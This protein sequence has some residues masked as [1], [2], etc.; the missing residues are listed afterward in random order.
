MAKLNVAVLMGGRS[1]EREVSLASGKNV[2][3][4]LD[5]AKYY[6]IPVEI[7]EDG[8]WVAWDMSYKRQYP[9]RLEPANFTAADKKVDVVFIALHGK[10][11]EDGTVQGF[12]EMMGVPYT[13]SGVLASALAM[14]KLLSKKIFIQE[15]IPTNEF[16]EVDFLS[17]SNK[18]PQILSRIIHKLGRPVVVKPS[19]EG[20]S[21][22][23]S[24]AYTDEQIAK[25]LDKAF[26]YGENVLA[27]RHL[28]AREIQCGIV[29]NKKPFALPLIEIISKK[30]FFDYEAKYT[31]ELAEEIVP[32]PI[33][34]EERKRVQDIS[35]KAYRAFGCRGF[36]RVD[37]FLQE[38]GQIFVSEINT[39][40]GLTASS[41]FPKEAEAGGI[42]FP[43]LLSILIELALEEK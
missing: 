18:A 1:S 29:G 16:V 8:N 5:S 37:T 6:A 43:K 22:G 24:I 15:K 17:W 7:T 36:A 27:E 38:D 12:L 9:V 30:E 25:A 10:L 14:N 41:L 39:I 20:S 33:S 19:C 26:S 28:K 11:G 4:F 3:Q 35:L 23:V 40:P 31:P 21:V 32:A 13:G 34:E 42:K 2:A